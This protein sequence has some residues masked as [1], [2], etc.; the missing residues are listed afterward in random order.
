MLPEAVK[1][2]IYSIFLSLTTLVGFIPWHTIEESKDEGEEENKVEE[3]A[4]HD[5]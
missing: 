3:P 5:G 4:E 2:S 1:T